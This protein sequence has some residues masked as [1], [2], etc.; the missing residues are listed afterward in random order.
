MKSR[1]ALRNSRPA[2]RRDGPR[3]VQAVPMAAAVAPIAELAPAR[4]LV[5]LHVRKAAAPAG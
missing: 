5:P 3:P 1:Q 2:A 4:K